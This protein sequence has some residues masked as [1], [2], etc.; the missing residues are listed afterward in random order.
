MFLDNKLLIVLVCLTIPS[1]YI[2]KP[3]K[4]MDGS[5][6]DV[7]LDHYHRYKVSW[8]Q[9]EQKLYAFICTFIGIS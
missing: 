3:G 8:H 5:N 9:K 7:A 4:I 1:L 2:N 6:G